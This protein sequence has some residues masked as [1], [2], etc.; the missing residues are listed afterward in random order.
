MGLSVSSAG[1]ARSIPK[2]K[3]ELLDL[4]MRDENIYYDNDK[5]MILD[6]NLNP[7]YMNRPQTE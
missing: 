6:N 2:L 1:G 7:Y 4:G 3:E 5:N